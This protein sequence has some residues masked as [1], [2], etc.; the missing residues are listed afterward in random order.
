MT[1]HTFSA[2]DIFAPIFRCTLSQIYISKKF[3]LVLLRCIFKTYFFYA[4]FIMWGKVRLK[5]CLSLHLLTLRHH[6]TISGHSVSFQG[7]KASCSCTL[8]LCLVTVCIIVVP[9]DHSVSFSGTICS[10]STRMYAAV[11]RSKA[12]LG[13]IVPS[14]IMVLGDHAVS[15][16]GLYVAR[17]H[18]RMLQ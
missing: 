18:V 6:V 4:H 1:L 12:F 10:N 8:T 13:D 3:N 7:L 9:G 16:Q 17:A 11:Q 2:P 5:T 15:F 14:A